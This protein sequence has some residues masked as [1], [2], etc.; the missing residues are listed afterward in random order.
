MAEYSFS[1]GNEC[2]VVSSKEV[3]AKRLLYSLILDG[4]LRVSGGR[5]REYEC[6]IAENRWS[7]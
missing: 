2:L 5:F 1:N 3:I 6:G 4:S 7:E